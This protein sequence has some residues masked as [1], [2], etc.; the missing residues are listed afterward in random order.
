MKPKHR[1]KKLICY[2]DTDSFIVY[3]Y[4]KKKIDIDIAKDV[5]TK[6]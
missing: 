6:I 3:I 5:G 1:E 4:L 2:T